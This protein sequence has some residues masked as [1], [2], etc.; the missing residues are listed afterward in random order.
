LSPLVQ[1]AGSPTVEDLENLHN[2]GV[3]AVI[4][5]A[6]T[7]S[8]D[9][10]PDEDRVVKGLGMEY[11]HIPVIWESPTL[12]NLQSFFAACLRCSGRK[13]FIHCVKNM[14]VSAFLYLYRVMC[15]GTDPQEAYADMAKIW[16]PEGNWAEFIEQ[17]LASGR[18]TAG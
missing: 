7:T 2:T 5:L 1:T 11:I 6:L 14:R 15:L 13:V 17:A 12:D 16:V 10:I 8:M 9:A 3:D 18:L 4:N